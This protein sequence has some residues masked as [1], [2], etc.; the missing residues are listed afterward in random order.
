MSARA[1]QEILE[2]LDALDRDELRQVNKAVQQRLE[3][4]EVNQRNK[5]F[6]QAL[7]DAGL[8]KE[9]PQRGAGNNARTLVAVSDEPVSE[10]IKRERR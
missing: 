9:S 6:Q 8:I 2:H 10:T 7:R 3:P 5:R 4:V 1:L